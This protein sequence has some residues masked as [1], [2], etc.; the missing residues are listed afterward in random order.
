MRLRECFLR[1]GK[2]IAEGK[3]EHSCPAAA[4]FSTTAR[5]LYVRVMSDTGHLFAR[6][7]EKAANA[8]SDQRACRE[9]RVW[10][11]CIRA[12]C[13]DDTRCVPPLR[14]GIHRVICLSPEIF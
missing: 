2:R 8:K 12:A 11:L 5:R 7:I 1:A 6:D 3:L 14:N 9:L 13:C 4:A 10:L